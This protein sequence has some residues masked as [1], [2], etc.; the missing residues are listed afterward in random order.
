MT[1]PP[2]QVSSAFAAPIV[3]TQL[4]DA[5]PLN[6][7]LR[8]LFLVREG[9]GD[10]YRKRLK[11]PTAQVNIFESEFDLFNWPDPPVQA[12]R[13]F[14]LNALGRAVVEL[15]EYSVEQTQQLNQLQLVVDSWFHV[16]RSGGYIGAHTHP[17][18]SWSG[19]YCVSPGEEPPDHPESGV[20]RFLDA[21]PYANMYLDAG[22]VRLKRPYGSGGIDYKLKGGQLVMFPSYLVHEATAFFG[23]DERITV[24]FNAAFVSKPGAPTFG[25]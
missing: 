5:E 25:F 13:G 17:L 19:V 11:T 24:S 4:P 22:N 9:Q 7:Q 23:R 8:E 3:T 21:R 20:L 18:A 6:R 14:C 15:N 2:L 10:R 16:T 1:P 12:L